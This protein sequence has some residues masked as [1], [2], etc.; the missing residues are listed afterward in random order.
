MDLESLGGGAGAGGVIATILALM[1]V[2]RKQDKKVCEAV[3]HGIED[4][5][6]TIV[7]VMKEMR[8][9]QKKIWERLDNFNDYMRNQK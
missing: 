9:G 7:D 3:H 8:E 6:E 2:N 5:F 1:G 4:K